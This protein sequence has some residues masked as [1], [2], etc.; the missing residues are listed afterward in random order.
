MTKAQVVAETHSIV[1]QKTIVDTA[2]QKEL[3]FKDLSFYVE[4][5]K[6]KSPFHILKS[7]SG[8]AKPGEVLGI[9]GASGSGKSTLLDFLFG[10]LSSGVASGEILVNGAPQ[11]HDSFKHFAA[12]VPQEDHLMGTMTVHETL[13][14]AAEMTLPASKSREYKEE[15]VT[16]VLEELGLVSCQD[17]KIGTVFQKGISGGQKRR[18]SLAVEMIS[19]PRILMLDEPT[20]GLD[21]L[22]AFQLVSNLKTLAR[23]G[24]SIIA[25]IHQPSSET[26]HM[27]DRLLLLHKGEVV[28]FDKVDKV[29]S[30]FANLGHQC[31][32]YTNP[33]DYVL[34]LINTDF[35]MKVD[36]PKLITAYKESNQE[37]VAYIKDCQQ[38]HAK[39]ESD[40]DEN[41]TFQSTVVKQFGQLAIRFWKDNVR[42]PGVFW[43]RMFMYTM[44]SI[45]IGTIYLNIGNGQNEVQDRGGILF[46]I[47][48]FMVF[49]AVSVIPAFIQDKAVYNRETMNGWYSPGP[50]V[51]ASTLSSI[52]GLL[53]LSITSTVI[54]YPLVGLQSGADRFF[55]FLADLFL[56]LWCS[57]ALMMLISVL[58]PFYIIGM[59]LGAGVY[60]MFMLTEGFLVLKSNLPVYWIWSYYIGFHTYSFRV[61]MFNEFDGLDIECDQSV[62]AYKSGEDVLDVYDMEDVNIGADLLV[63]FCIGLFF[64]I[65]CYVMLKILHKRSLPINKDAN[66][67]TSAGETA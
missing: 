55:I 40:I 66:M 34:Q 50:Y 5:G 61:F 17:T 41:H 67:L 6:T 14:F 26:F 2:D 52:P 44:L 33:A 28:Y 13:M 48:A 60:G 49:M 8:F 47:A 4:K 37:T 27:L 57:E 36:V 35:G 30:Y 38:R 54:I 51:V 7:I 62:C 65:M 43:V 53:L 46:Y 31:P 1:E 3:E 64:R 15:K 25:T 56:S 19:N 9:M 45:M 42:N 11:N 58:V 29:V 23:G 20:S 32:T 18:V 63:L 21:S 10:R 12:Y 24:R 16:T 59:A 22:A 39:E